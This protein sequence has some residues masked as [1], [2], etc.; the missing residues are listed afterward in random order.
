MSSNKGQH[1]NFEISVTSQSNLKDGFSESDMYPVSSGVNC[2]LPKLNSK[3]FNGD[4]LDWPEWSCK[5]L[6][7][8][9]R[10]TISDDKK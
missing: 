9:D 2:A 6:S 3:E 4:P 7:T 10:S 5:F 8:I 1:S